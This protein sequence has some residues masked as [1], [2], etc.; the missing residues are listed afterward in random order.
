MPPTTAMAMP[1]PQFA[2]DY[3]EACDIRDPQSHCGD[4]V[5]ELRVCIYSTSFGISV[6]GKIV[7]PLIPISQKCLDS[8][9]WSVVWRM[10]EITPRILGY[11]AQEYYKHQSPR[12]S[13][14][15][16]ISTSPYFQRYEDTQ[17]TSASP[18]QSQDPGLFF[19]QCCS[20]R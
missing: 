8:R 13:F 20:L 9:R 3:N 17:H 4:L 16:S 7:G 19:A 1:E 6:R 18:A 15:S 11:V 12:D 2:P 14:K 5:L 10:R